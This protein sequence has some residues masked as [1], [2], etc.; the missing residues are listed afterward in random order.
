MTHHETPIILLIFQPTIF[1]ACLKHALKETYLHSKSYS[2][3][4]QFA[5][6]FA[7]GFKQIKHT[8]KVWLQ[9]LKRFRR[10]KWNIMFWSLV[11]GNSDN[12]NHDGFC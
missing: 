4:S 6:W 5:K 9:E 7:N 3:W 1:N 10:D 2:T 12:D 8:T 11:T